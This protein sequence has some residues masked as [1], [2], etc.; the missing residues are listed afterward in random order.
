MCPRCAEAM[1]AFELEG[2]EIDRCIVCR[3]T[4][5]DAG[6]LETISKLSGA[7]T[8]ELGRALAFPADGD[9]VALGCPR[10]PQRLR[11]RRI[12]RNGKVVLDHCPSGHGLWFDR[13][14]LFAVLRS[15]ADSQAEA[16]TRFFTDL[17]SSE[18]ESGSTGD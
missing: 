13:G 3:G 2:V 17:Y 16:V 4:W 12:G 11:E 6:E 14:E 15:Y 5:L 8:G 18:L 9:R 10:C 1:V 7:S